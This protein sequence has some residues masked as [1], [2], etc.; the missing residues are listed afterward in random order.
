[1]P[2]NPF[3][4]FADSPTSAAADGFAITPH[5]T[6]PLPSITKAIYVGGAGDVVVRL[7]SASSDVV[8]RNV[9]AGTILD[10]RVLAVRAAGTTATHIVGLA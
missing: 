4:T 9:A 3:D 1:M 5:P 7:L 10:I 8:F 2:A 6:D